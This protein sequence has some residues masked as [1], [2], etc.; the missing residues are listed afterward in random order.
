[1]AMIGFSESDYTAVEGGEDI[2]VCIVLVS[3]TGQV[4][5]EVFVGINTVRGSPLSFSVSG[6]VNLTGIEV[7][8][9]ILCGSPV[10]EDDMI[11]ME[12]QQSILSAFVE[13]FAVT[14]AP[15]GD[16]A[17]IIVIDNDG[18]YN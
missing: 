9:A 15:D 13:A 4:N 11:F 18:M 17:S 10:I 6:A 16:S 7:G 8:E 1:M 2:S 14:F 3:L 5:E 12:L